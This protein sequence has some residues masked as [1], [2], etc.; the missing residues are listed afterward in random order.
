[1]SDF[2][3]VNKRLPGEEVDVVD[4]RVIPSTSPY[5]VRLTEVP[6]RYISTITTDDMVL[7]EQVGSLSPLP[8]KFLVDYSN[9][10]ITF[11]AAQLGESVSIS[12]QGTGSV[13]WAED[14]NEIID[15]RGSMDS[16]DERLDVFL[17][18]DGTPRSS[19]ITVAASGTMVAV[20][21][22]DV[23]VS[24]YPSAISFNHGFDVDVDVNPTGIVSVDIDESELDPELIPVVPSG[25]LSSTNVQDILDEVI[26]RVILPSYTQ[27]EI[28]ALPES[29]KEIGELFYVTDEETV[30]IWNGISVT[31]L[32]IGGE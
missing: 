3:F 23:D 13:I 28:I 12:Y 5:E 2:S 4:V 14:F 9:G 25:W 32:T 26:T 22:D 31:L 20:K 8:G 1:M 7:Y 21:E 15:A 18:D 27:A 11:N 17:N 30:G 29:E 24:T 6:L 16:L 10:S 19:W